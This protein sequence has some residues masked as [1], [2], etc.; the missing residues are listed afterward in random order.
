MNEQKYTLEEFVKMFNVTDEEEAFK[1]P[2]WSNYYLTDT[3]EDGSQKLRRR[4]TFH[5]ADDEL[6]ED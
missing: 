6:Q 3:L 4:P 5:I 2:L 1:G